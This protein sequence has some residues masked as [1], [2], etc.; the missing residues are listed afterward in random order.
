MVMLLKAYVDT[1]EEACSARRLGVPAIYRTE[2]TLLAPDRISLMRSVV[3]AEEDGARDRAIDALRPLLRSDLVAIFRTVSQGSITVRLLDPPLDRFLPTPQQIAEDYAEARSNENYDDLFTL[4]NLRHRVSHVRARSSVSHRGCRLSLTN[5]QILRL[6]VAAAL[7]AG[8]ELQGGGV[9]LELT[10]L[11]P[12]V[13]S[14][15]E[16]CILAKSVR[17]IAADVFLHR[18]QMISY[19]LGAL[20]ESPRAA[21]CAAEIARYVDVVAFGTN[22]LTRLTYGF[23]KDDI[24]SY[25]D[26]YLERSILTHDPFVV[27]DQQGVGHLMKDAI[28]RIRQH[29]PG[30]TIG[31]CGDH[32]ADP[33]SLRFFES[34]GVNFAAC[35]LPILEQAGRSLS[36]LPS[37]TV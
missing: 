21:I 17:E 15:E 14:E 13:S 18:G 31:V 5:P 33:E 28:Q 24:N 19:Q 7:E 11:M 29:Y 8:L 32:S 34:L 27:L 1:H 37:A 26:C 22:D 4:S 3:M 36:H 6:Q 2:P 16:I 25:L 35:A 23:S 12:L 20:I 30:V 9:S 10:L